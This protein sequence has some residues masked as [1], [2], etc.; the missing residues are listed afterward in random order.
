MI[1]VGWSEGGSAMTRRGGASK[2]GKLNSERSRRNGS[3]RKKKRSSRCAAAS[4]AK[5]ASTAAPRRKAKKGVRTMAGPNARMGLQRWPSF[6]AISRLFEKPAMRGLVGLA[7]A[8][9]PVEQ[10]AAREAVGHEPRARL[11]IAQCRAR[12]RAEIAVIF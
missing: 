1:P 12:A 2:P 3:R 9:Q 8:P 5:P 11:K 7:A 6:E 10:L 4:F